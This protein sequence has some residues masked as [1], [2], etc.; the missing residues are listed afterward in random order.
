MSDLVLGLSAY[1][2]DSAAALIADGVPVAAAQEERFSRRRHDPAFPARAVEYCLRESGVTLDDVSAVA[3]Y[4]DPALKFRR[5]L[6]SYLGAAP[7]GFGSFA[8]GVPE[9]LSWKRRATEVV[10]A[11][12]AALGRGEVPS[13][14]VRRHHASHAA[15]AFLPSPYESAA[16]L[17]VDGVGEWATT[18]LWHGRGSDLRQLGELRFP[19]S[20]GLLYSAFTYFCGFKVDSGEY[21]LMGLA[22]Y[23]KPRYA[24]L[25]RERLID[26]KPDGSF[27]L[28]M[29][30]FAFLEGEVMTGRAFE[31]L[32]GGPRRNPEGP[33]TEREFDLAAS[34]Q[35]VTEEVMIRLARTA[36]ERTGE[37][38]LCL[39]G[40]VALNCVANGRVIEEGIFDE[41]WIQPAAG[42]A[43]GALGAALAVAADRGA[44]RAHLGSGRD[45]MSGAL[46]G[47]DY[48]DAE[49]A[50]YLDNRS[51]PYTRLDPASVADRLAKELASGK[52][53]GW[54][55]GRSEFGPR[56]LGA[57]SILGDPRD[58]RMQSA[59]NLKI[60]FR[61]SFRPFA[62]SVL[63]EDAGDY[64]DLRQESPYMLVVAGVAA[65][66]RLDPPTDTGAAAGLGLLRV[67][68]SRIPAVTHVDSSAR[69]Q[70]V[71]AGANPAY[72]RL[73]TAFKAETGCPVLVNTSFN[74]RGEPI[75]NSP[76]DAYTCFMRTGI[77]VLAIGSF[78]L[79]KADQPRWQESGDWREEIP[80]D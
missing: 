45:A 42:D 4:E 9:W 41:V 49:I 38:R 1:Y 23:G 2:H 46:L 69:V 61:E 18:T 39:A 71:S 31:K 25:I 19:H 53:A 40:G 58:P 75:V 77:D 15:S 44:P 67:P 36:R 32:F 30:H 14:E 29:R 50:E 55:Q 64:F 51:I 26:I 8:R 48:G 65:G 57:R 59:M 76:H 27:R 3:Y 24:G 33:L 68:R 34:V 10:T 79:D 22:P 63:G 73:L 47:P 78:L 80:L 43:G 20:L 35:E 70:T 56:A 60:K 5:V 72:H 11:E 13:V 66:Q 62:P 74:V 6:A 12:L 17:C 7:L 16:V 37:S 54:F 21:K 52:V 28:D